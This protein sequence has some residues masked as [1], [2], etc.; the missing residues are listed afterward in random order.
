[1]SYYNSSSRRPNT[2]Q[3]LP[4]LGITSSYPSTAP[5]NTTSSAATGS[6]NNATM[7][8]LFGSAASSANANPTQG[9]L[10]KDV[11]VSDP[12]TDSISD[13]VFSPASDHLAVAS[14]DNK[15]RIYSVDQ[16]G[17]SSGVAF[18][19]HQGPAMNCCWSKVCQYCLVCPGNMIAV[20]I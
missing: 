20:L 8:G 16:N 19:E 6:S 10:T 11:Q 14:W 18:F 7:S 2:S 13:M 17:Q 12:P 15:V 9:D 5:S 1:M 4:G 3:K